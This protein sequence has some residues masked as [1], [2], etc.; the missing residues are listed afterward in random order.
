MLSKTDLFLRFEIYMHT[1]TPFRFE[2]SLRILYPDP[3]DWSI[4][5][6]FANMLWSRLD[7]K[8]TV[9]LIHDCVSYT[10]DQT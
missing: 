6:A 10:Y 4:I 7:N 3:V 2:V 8:I 9:S 1:N 5:L